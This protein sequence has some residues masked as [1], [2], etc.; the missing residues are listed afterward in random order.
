[1]GFGPNDIAEEEAAGT[2]LTDSVRGVAVMAAR[3][4]QGSTSVEVGIFHLQPVK[5]FDICFC[6]GL[7]ATE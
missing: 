4:S 2:G 3:F 5:I 7:E 6:W 1:M